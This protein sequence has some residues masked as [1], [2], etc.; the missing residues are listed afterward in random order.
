[1]E[2]S[3]LMRLRIAAAMAVG[4]VLLGILPWSLVRPADSLGA[5]TL[6]SGDIGV[7]DALIS[8][9]LAFLSGFG[10]YFVSYPYG[11]EIAPLAAPAGM[12]LWVFRS[13][14]M[15]SLLR[16]NPAVEDR[17]AIYGVLK[18][19]GFFWLAIAGAGYFGVVVAMR[20]F[21]PQSQDDQPEKAHN[22][23]PNRVFSIAT[24]IVATVVI[25]HFLIGIL[26]QDVRRYDSE[27]GSVVGQPGIGQ[28]VFAVIV[29]FAI[30]GW[31]LKEFL[32]ISY[33]WPCVG[34]AGLTVFS[35]HFFAEGEMLTY[36]AE[37]WP[38]AFF[39]RAT[40]AILP[41]QI[42]SCAAIGS[43]AG[44]WLAVKHAYWRK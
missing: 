9:A 11:Q 41:L 38:V 39:A 37:N 13:G 16:V 43:I 12:A 40:I 32:D 17:Q 21:G 2:L 10:A 23:C 28:I 44:Y 30:A 42:V 6:C 25:T 18:W 22:S 3:L 5:I 19:E 4:V 27:V 20:F 29:S 14:D 7:F 35:V 34:A 8:L 26:A 24:A 31:A 36:M 33:I 1:M 15:A